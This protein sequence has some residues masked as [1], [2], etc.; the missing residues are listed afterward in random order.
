ME[1]K[2]MKVDGRSADGR[3]A[4]ENPLNG[5]FLYHVAHADTF[6]QYEV[7]E[8]RA[9]VKNVIRRAAKG[10]LGSFQMKWRKT[11]TNKWFVIDKSEFDPLFFFRFVEKKIF[12]LRRGLHFFEEEIEDLEDLI[13]GDSEASKGGG[14]KEI[15]DQIKE[16]IQAL[17]KFRDAF[18]LASNKPS[19]YKD[20]DN[21]TSFS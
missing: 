18:L 2:R 7:E 10:E 17:K 4:T 21:L 20:E 15:E 19:W 16:E 5:L 12:N 13:I 11:G 14:D 1:V 3:S 9:K 8:W 6:N